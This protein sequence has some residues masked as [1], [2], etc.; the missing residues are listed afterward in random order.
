MLV[1]PQILIYLARPGELVLDSGGWRHADR[2]LR[3]ELGTHQTQS[4]EELGR[5]LNNY[6]RRASA[7]IDARRGVIVQDALEVLAC[8]QRLGFEEASFFGSFEED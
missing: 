2:V 4:L 5:I 1:E 6:D 7:R 8:V 3:Y